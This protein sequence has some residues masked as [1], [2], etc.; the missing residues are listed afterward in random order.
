MLLTLLTGS[1]LI[2]AWSVNQTDAAGSRM[3]RPTLGAHGLGSGIDATP[4]P[5][6]HASAGL[7]R[8]QPRGTRNCTATVPRSQIVDPKKPGPWGGLLLAKTHCYE[9]SVGP[10]WLSR[11]PSRAEE[12]AKMVLQEPAASCSHRHFVW[13]NLGDHNCACAPPALDCAGRA[14]DTPAIFASLY[15]ILDPQHPDLTRVEGCHLGPLSGAGVV[16][17]AAGRNIAEH[18]ANLHDTVQVLRN[19]FGWVKLIFEAAASDD[20][21]IGVMHRLGGEVL[22][23]MPLEGEHRSKRTVRLAVA[24]NRLLNRVR[25][26]QQEPEYVLMF[27]M[28]EATRGFSGIASCGS[29]PEDWM[30]CCANTVHTDGRA[31]YD[32]WALRT[33]ETD[34]WA[35]RD[36]VWDCS[37]KQWQGHFECKRLRTAG[38]PYAVDSCFGGAVLYKWR[39]LRDGS[40]VYAGVMPRITDSGTTDAC[41]VCEHVPMHAAVRRRHPNTSMY[42]ARNFSVQGEAF[43]HC[44]G[45]TVI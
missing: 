22:P 30:G 18:E 11:F 31:Y 36:M 14:H 21:T 20:D 26:L 16:A 39:Y 32:M 43:S 24:R 33:V 35:P 1:R 6:P 5:R 12:C 9:K 38:A 44:H 10:L 27:D 23:V 2:P 29:L 45:P 15:T 42:I 13:A 8:A 17:V 19:T 28:D 4:F 25:E 41:D 7:A 3:S 40:A 37:K 34:G